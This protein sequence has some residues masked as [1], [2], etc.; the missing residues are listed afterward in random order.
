LGQQILDDVHV[1][2]RGQV[3]TEGGVA[4]AGTGPEDGVATLASVEVT[5]FLAVQGGRT[6]ADTVGFAMAADGAGHVGL[7]KSN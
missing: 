2:E 1:V 7:Q 6:A 5:E 3:E 4:A